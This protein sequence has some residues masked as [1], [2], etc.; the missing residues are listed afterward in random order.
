MRF[1][2]QGD[3]FLT[4]ENFVVV[5]IPFQGDLNTVWDIFPHLAVRLDVF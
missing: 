2:G 1:T 5:G 4:R 3:I